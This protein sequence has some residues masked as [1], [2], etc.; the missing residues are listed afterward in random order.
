MISFGFRMSPNHSL[1]FSKK[2]IDKISSD[3]YI[4]IN[5][6]DQTLEIII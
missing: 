4:I 6:S 3:I 2:I 5:L 1:Q